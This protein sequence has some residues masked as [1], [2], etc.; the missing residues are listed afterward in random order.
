MGRGVCPA[1]SYR[2]VANEGRDGAE[3]EPRAGG[4]ERSRPKGQKQRVGWGPQI[5]DLRSRKPLPGADSASGRPAPPT[6]AGLSR[7]G[8]GTCS[9]QSHKPGTPTEGSR[10]GLPAPE[11][12]PKLRGPPCPARPAPYLAGAVLRRR[13][14]R[15]GGWAAQSH[16]VPG[17]GGRSQLRVTSAANNEGFDRRGA[18]PA[19]SP[20]PRPPPT[21]RPARPGPSPPPPRIRL[22][23]GGPA[24]AAPVPQ[25]PAPPRAPR[26][27]P[28]GGRF[29]EGSGDPSPAAPRV[30]RVGGRAIRPEARSPAL[31]FP[32]PPR[33]PSPLRSRQASPSGPGR[34]PGASA[35]PPAPPSPPR[36]RQPRLR[37]APGP[38]PSELRLGPRA[39]P[40]S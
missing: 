22:Q 3:P 37:L 26:C 21:P 24:P 20:A 28:S 25:P 39:P 7:V 9:S 29:Q 8:Q 5:W 11:R 6:C 18:R 4:R 30:P 27:T 12:T 16:I 2:G 1:R 31:A 40:S 35:E 17:R 19:R 23:S 34:P 13:R 14:R 36:L 33:A 38:G 10:R 32:A 15:H